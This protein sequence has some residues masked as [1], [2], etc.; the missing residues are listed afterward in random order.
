MASKQITENLTPL[1][2]AIYRLVDEDLLYGRNEGWKPDN[3][4]EY[5]RGRAKQL[6]AEVVSAIIT[7]CEPR[8]EK[9]ESPETTKYGIY[10]IRR[11]V[12]DINELRGGRVNVFDAV[13]VLGKSTVYH[14]CNLLI[15]DSLADIGSVRFVKPGDELSIP[16][17]SGGFEPIIITPENMIHYADTILRGRY[18]NL[19]LGQERF[20]IKVEA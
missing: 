16:L 12:W 5:A 10:H 11:P 13:L 19:I 7:N 20:D 8:I 9:S 1:Q 14:P 15:E 6:A 18:K 2:N 17:H 4:F 3:P